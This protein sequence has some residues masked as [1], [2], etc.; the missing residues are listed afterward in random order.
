MMPVWKCA[1]TPDWTAVVGEELYDHLNDTGFDTD[2]AENDNVVAAPEN[3]EL[4][5]ELYAALRAGWKAALPKAS[6]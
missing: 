3:A 4:K 1:Q 5:A 2:F 6:Q